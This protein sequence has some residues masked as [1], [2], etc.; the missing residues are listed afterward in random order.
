MFPY[1]TN[2]RGSRSGDREE[3]P[4]AN[5]QMS[6]S[7][8]SSLYGGGAPRPNTSHGHRPQTAGR[9]HTSHTHSTSV[10]SFP[11][12][13]N[14]YMGGLGSGS[15]AGG[16]PA[17]K[18]HHRS[19]TLRDVRDL[20]PETIEPP[21]SAWSALG[22]LR[23]RIRRLNMESEM[24]GD[25]ENSEDSAGTETE[26]EGVSRADGDTSF[27]S[28]ESSES[29]ESIESEMEHQRA[30]IQQPLQTQ[31]TGQSTMSN[32]DHSE[33]M[34]DIEMS[35][36]RLKNLDADLYESLYTMYEEM[37]ALCHLPGQ[38]GLSEGIS[39]NLVALSSFVKILEKKLEIHAIKRTNRRSVIGVVSP[40]G[41]S[42]SSPYQSPYTQQQIP[43]SQQQQY[44]PQFV[45][46]PPQHPT[47]PRMPRSSSLR[48]VTP[49]T[50]SELGTPSYARRLAAHNRRQKSMSMSP[51][52]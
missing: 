17:Y 4:F 49:A 42:S 44:A 20:E 26:Q 19:S 16:K 36:N 9:P 1:K 52:F 18:S 15:P 31:H 23:E 5:T 33:D 22:A 34:I 6:R 48:S 27:A 28:N 35:L 43:P 38:S 25:D 30:H 40:Q 45:Q 12:F 7:R 47:T 8:S 24:E 13:N 46:P 51:D 29:C 50:P 37:T 41:Y 21:S 11:A 10:N 39:N 14:G 3:N 32:F 2:R